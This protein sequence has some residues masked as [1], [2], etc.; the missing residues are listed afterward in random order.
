MEDRAVD[1]GVFIVGSEYSVEILD[2]SLTI[3]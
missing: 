3:S 1:L 2:K